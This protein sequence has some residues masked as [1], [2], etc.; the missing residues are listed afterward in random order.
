MNSKTNKINPI[1]NMNY[2]IPE[3]TCGHC[4]K[5]FILPVDA[6]I[7]RYVYKKM[8]GK[9]MVYYHCYTCYRAATKDEEEKL[10]E[11]KEAR[12]IAAK[13]RNAEYFEAYKARKAA[14]A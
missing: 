10:A 2:L 9:K 12:S 5:K 14:Q 8:I 1:F 11:A 7:K 4:G 6:D 13:I 3:Y